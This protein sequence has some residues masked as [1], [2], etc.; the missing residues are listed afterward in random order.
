MNIP[1]LD[2]PICYIHYISQLP[3]NSPT[4]DQFTMYTRLNIYIV[5]IDNE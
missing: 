4:I 3:P 5:V 2:D 1:I